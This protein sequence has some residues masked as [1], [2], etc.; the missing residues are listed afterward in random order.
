MQYFETLAWPT[1]FWVAIALGCIATLLFAFG[2]FDR[3]TFERDS[4]RPETRFRPQEL[5]SRQ[6]YL[7]SFVLYVLGLEFAYLAICIIGPAPIIELGLAG[8]GRHTF[9]SAASFPLWVAM[10]MIGVVP[11]LP[12]L[13]NIEQSW[14]RLMH[15]RASIPAAATSLAREMHSA[16]Y[17]VEPFR[18]YLMASGAGY[19]VTEADFDA[20][21]HSTSSR[22]VRLSAMIWRLDTLEIVPG[23]ERHLDFDFIERHRDEIDALRFAYRQTLERVRAG[24]MTDADGCAGPVPEENAQA[25]E[26]LQRRLCLFLACALIARKG[27]RE[28][29]SRGVQ[30]L[31]FTARHEPKTANDI[32]VLL[33]SFSCAVAV[34]FMTV[35]LA[36]N[37]GPFLPEAFVET[38]WPEQKATDSFA[39]T[40]SAALMHGSAVFT[41]L[42][43]RRHLR[44]RH[45][46]FRVTLGALERPKFVRYLMTAG[47]AFLVSL[48]AI[49]YWDGILRGA[50]VIW[51][52]LPTRYPFGLVAAASALFVC[53]IVDR[54]HMHSSR[55]DLSRLVAWQV[56][57]TG[58]LAWIAADHLYGYEEGH[59]G[60][61]AF[62]TLSATL[63]AAALGGATAWLVRV[64]AAD[65]AATPQSAA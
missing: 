24:R 11:R 10:V 31:G 3:P 30:E 32:D 45:R 60:A 8:E 18:N 22:W 38:G 43:I 23:L 41:A 2:E 25:I 46:W 33:Q 54:A 7:I 16:G 37:I 21:P 19:A 28:P 61:I 59:M 62:T 56:A 57:V 29:V 58:L 52:D 4:A 34:Y 35:F 50:N 5:T 1:E 39:W 15:E 14:R 48:A 17:D 49:S 36:L 26:G 13:A 20:D 65:Y 55:R 51:D 63:F 9:E 12:V 6:D 64:D 44:R 40:F 47:F 42:M 27:R 53:M